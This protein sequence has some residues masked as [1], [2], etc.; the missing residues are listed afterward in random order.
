MKFVLYYLVFY[1]NLVL[2]FLFVVVLYLGGWEFLFLV[3]FIFN[4]FGVS[5]IIF[6]L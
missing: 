2:F 4:W 6:W 1:V 5:E 3:E